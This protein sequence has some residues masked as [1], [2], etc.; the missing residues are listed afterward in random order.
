MGRYSN[1]W[2]SKHVNLHIHS[3]YVIG[4]FDA[5]FFLLLCTLGISCHLLI[6][7]VCAVKVTVLGLCVCLCVTSLHA[8]KGVYTTKWIYRLVLH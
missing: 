8:A 5:L 7:G 1:Y 4:V 2:H 3:M 6:L